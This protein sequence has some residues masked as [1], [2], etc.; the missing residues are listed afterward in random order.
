MIASYNPD[1]NEIAER[2]N[3]MIM[4][5]VKAIIRRAKLDKR[6][7]MEIIDIIVYLKNRNPITSLDEKTSYEAW[8]ERNRIY[9]ASESLETQRISTFQRKSARSSIPILIREF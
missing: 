9:L 1:Q 7:W 4:K 6:L 8:H 2:A 5:R 3:R